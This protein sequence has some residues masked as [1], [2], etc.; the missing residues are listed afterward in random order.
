MFIIYY[1]CV[2]KPLISWN[3]ERVATVSRERTGGQ[4]INQ[5]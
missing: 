4:G 2:I 1:S 3:L 5:F